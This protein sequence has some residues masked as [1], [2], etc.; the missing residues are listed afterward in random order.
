MRTKIELITNYGIVEGVMG[1]G[2]MKININV[3]KFDCTKDRDKLIFN[4]YIMRKE[5]L[6]RIKKGL[7]SG[8]FM[9]SV[10]SVASDLGISRAKAQRLIKEF[11]DKNIIKSI[12]KGNSRDRGASVYLYLTGD[13][14][15]DIGN[16]IEI[17]SSTN[18]FI[19]NDDTNFDIVDDNSKIDNINTKLNN[20]DICA[21]VIDYLNQVTG[22]CFKPSTKKTISSIQARLNEGFVE[23][24]FYRVIDIKSKQWLHN[25][26]NK[27][28]RP[29][30]L[31]SNKFEGYLNENVSV[32][33]VDDD[34][35]NEWDVE[36]DY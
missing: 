36:F 12:L 32:S 35:V 5:N 3:M 11:E 6:N 31:F 23:E 20:K 4:H 24:D 16:N 18:G 19:D 28:L 7:P 25:D 34:A 17:D 21:G 27:F 13:T 30:T 1:Y 9:M 8:Q 29:E 22:K 33:D 15:N 26:M 14:V 2:Y 10:S